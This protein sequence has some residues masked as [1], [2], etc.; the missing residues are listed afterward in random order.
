MSYLTRLLDW[1]DDLPIPI[2]VLLLAAVMMI[3]T[4]GGFG[5]IL[6]AFWLLYK[7]GTVFA[8]LTLLFIVMVIIATMVIDE[9]E[10]DKR[11]AEQ[12]SNRFSDKW[13]SEKAEYSRQVRNRKV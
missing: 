3:G 13:R 11:A 5:T 10:S 9:R 2:R 12:R 6:G 8:V 4:I 7:L 1:F